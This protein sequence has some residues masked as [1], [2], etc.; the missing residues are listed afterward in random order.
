LL[1]CVAHRQAHRSVYLSAKPA[2]VR[3]A[4]RGCHHMPFVKHSEQRV[5]PLPASAMLDSQAGCQRP[6]DAV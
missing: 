6:I 2:A 4:L 3:L 1:R 5:K